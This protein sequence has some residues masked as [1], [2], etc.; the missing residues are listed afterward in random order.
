M[1][2]TMMHIKTETATKEEAAKIAEEL[3]FGTLTSM[4]NVLLKQLIRDRRITLSLDEIPNAQ[5][6]ADLKQGEEDVK[7]GRVTSFASG[8]D[9]LEYLAKEID[10]EK[11]A[12][13]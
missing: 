13:H 7:A 9:A 5:T 4:V 10:D 12:T 6:I 3:G 2:T 11:R 8:K 1:S